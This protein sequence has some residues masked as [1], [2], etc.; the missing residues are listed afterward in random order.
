VFE[1]RGGHDRMGRSDHG[2]GYDLV[3]LD[4]HA[5]KITAAV[6]DVENA[7]DALVPAAWRRFGVWCVL[8]G[9]GAAGARDV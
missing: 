8:F 4:V 1:P 3:G 5:A 9:F 6:F 7:G 2:E